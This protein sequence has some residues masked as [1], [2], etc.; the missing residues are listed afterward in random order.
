[1]NGTC[2]ELSLRCAFRACQRRRK[3]AILERISTVK[4]IEAALA[5]LSVP[6]LQAVRDWLDE[7]KAKLERAQSEIA[8]GIH[9][10]VRKPQSGQ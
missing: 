7:F 5:R 10:P 8:Q 9:S 3:S 6:D 2:F 1:M 4:E